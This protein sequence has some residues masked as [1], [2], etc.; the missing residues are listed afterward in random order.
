MSSNGAARPE[1]V[2]LDLWGQLR[3]VRRCLPLL[4][5]VR[6]HLAVLLIGMAVLAALGFSSFLIFAPAL[7]G[8][9][10]QGK[11]ISELAAFAVGLPVDGF[12]RVEALAPELRRVLAERLTWLLAGLALGIAAGIMAASY[13]GIWILQK[14]NQGLRLRLVDRLQVLSLRFHDQSRVGDAIYRT[15]QDSAMVTQ[16]VQSYVIAPIASL[17]QAITLTLVA[18]CFAPGL[19]LL[20][21]ATWPPLLALGLFFSRRLRA[22]FRVARETN[23]ALTSR[24]QESLSAVRVIKA[25]GLEG[26]EQERFE[27]ASRQAFAGARAAR[28]RLATFGVAVFWVVGSAIL[29]ASVLATLATREAAPLWIASLVTRSGFATLETW[30]AS[31][32]IGVWT[33]GIYNAWK[34]L[35]ASGAGSVVGIFRTWGRAQDIAVGLDRVFELLDLEPEVKDAPDAIALAPLRERI[36][37][38]DVSFAYRA[39]RPALEGVSFS[40][41]VGAITALVGP[42]GSGKSTAMALLLRLFDPDAGRIEI[43]GVDLRRLRIANLRRNIAIAL[44]E[45]VLF[46]ASVRENI[47]YAAPD[48]DDAEI[49]EAARVACADDFIAALPN[50]YD[51]LLGERGAK[52]STG[53]RQRINLARAVLKNAPIL[54]LDEPTAS[55]DAETEHRLVRN[56]AEWGKGRCVFLVTHRLSTVRLA[57]QIVHLERG[58]VAESGTHEELIA[59]PNGAY[60]ALVESELIDARVAP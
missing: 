52:L 16:V 17:T 39:D 32:G 50:G 11:P 26:F 27:A 29:A 41:P 14:V 54:I 33:L 60:R 15:Y 1:P 31:A 24:I 51:T 6:R 12:T 40:A 28:G 30:L 57:N 21:L 8:G 45:N 43:D 55:L 42:T 49:R 44:Q 23:S 48:A 36:A 20:L 34:G 9:A 10:L 4:R 37:F 58:R 47:R 56:L 3:V 53:Q 25:Y 18:A 38:R 22:D 2:D 19:A 35:F 46:A 59:R 13:Y 7:W 5:G